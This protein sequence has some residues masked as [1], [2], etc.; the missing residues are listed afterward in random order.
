[1]F[2]KNDL[3]KLLPLVK[4]ASFDSCSCLY[5]DN[6]EESNLEIETKAPHDY[7][8]RIDREVSDYLCSELP[9]I[10][11]ESQVLSEERK[12]KDLS[13]PYIW[14]I[15]PIDGTNNLIYGLP[16]YAV[17]I[18]LTCENKLILGVVYHP[19]T[20]E[21]FSAASGCGAFAENALI[22]GRP[23]KAIRVNGETDM[24]KIIIMSE[25]DPYFDRKKNPSMDLIKRVYRNCIDCRITGSA[26]IDM[27]FIAS[28]R[29]HTHFCRNLSPWDYAGGAAILTEAGGMV[30]QWDGSPI[31]FSIE[32]KHSNLASNNKV[33]HEAMLEIVKE[34]I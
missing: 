18:G 15:D 34:F 5:Q 3:D 23:A 4:K 21:L 20:G 33:I 7:L 16:F 19:A 27:S 17:S 8:T 10:M 6:A 12:N 11:K 1:M 9:K 24:D 25:T 31:T 2:G 22:P 13:A 32:K 30:S 14:I 28:G 26:A 29:A